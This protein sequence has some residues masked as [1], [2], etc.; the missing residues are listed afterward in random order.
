MNQPRIETVY[1]GELIV[2]RYTLFWILANV[3]VYGMFI[4]FVINHF[5]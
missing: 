4:G 5:V 2:A 3:F 1:A